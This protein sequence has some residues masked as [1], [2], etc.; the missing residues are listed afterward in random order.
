MAFT[1]NDN[2]DKYDLWIY[3]G[4][5]LNPISPNPNNIFIKNGVNFLILNSTV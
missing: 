2:P 3:D 1:I 5:G 4:T